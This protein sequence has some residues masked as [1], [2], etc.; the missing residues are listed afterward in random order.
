MPPPPRETATSLLIKMGLEKILREE[1]VRFPAVAPWEWGDITTTTVEISTTLDGCT[2][3]EDSIINKQ[4]AFNQ[5]LD[6]VDKDKDIIIYS[7]ASVTDGTEAGGGGIIIEWPATEEPTERIGVPAG[8]KC[9]SYKAPPWVRSLVE[10]DTGRSNLCC[11]IEL[12][13]S[14]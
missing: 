12:S 4:R 9:S 2:G 7:D 11:R 1:A 8:G 10:G 5:V 14:P 13:W 3:R 6:N